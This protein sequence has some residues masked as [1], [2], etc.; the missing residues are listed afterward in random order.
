MRRISALVV[1]VA[2]VLAGC[3]TNSEPTS[4][5][6]GEECLYDGPSEFDLDTE[7]KFAFVNTSEATSAGYGIWKVPDGTTVDG[8]S[9]KSIFGIGADMSTDMRAVARPSSPGFDK[10]LTVNLDTPGS[11]AI[12]C[13]DPNPAPAGTDYPATVFQVS[14]S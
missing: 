3:S 8:I 7:V 10:E 14:N 12:I 11:W 9:E 4:T 6:T 2:L 13:F 1:L 5:F